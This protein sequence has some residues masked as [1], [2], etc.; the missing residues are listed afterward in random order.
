LA[1]AVANGQRLVLTSPDGRQA[2]LAARDLLEAGRNAHGGA[3][4]ENALQWLQGGMM[5][6]PPARHLKRGGR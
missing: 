6:M 1:D 5:L 4:A 3:T 2:L